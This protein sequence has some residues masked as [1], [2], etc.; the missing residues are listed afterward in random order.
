[1]LCKNALCKNSL[2]NYLEELLQSQPTRLPSVLRKITIKGSICYLE[3]LL[4]ILEKIYKLFT[5]QNLNK[6]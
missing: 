5:T 6:I 4:Q 3:D 1:M 2:N